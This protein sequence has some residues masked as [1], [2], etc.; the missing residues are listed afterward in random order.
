MTAFI[1]LSNGEYHAETVQVG[2]GIRE[3]YVAVSRSE[4]VPVVEPGATLDDLVQAGLCANGILN[5]GFG[6]QILDA[7][8]VVEPVGA[9]FVEIPVHVVETPRIGLQLSDSL[10]PLF[11][12]FSSHQAYLLMTE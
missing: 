2:S 7:V 12:E 1:S 5:L 10:G 9:P 3:I 8:V 11:L 4:V 6:G